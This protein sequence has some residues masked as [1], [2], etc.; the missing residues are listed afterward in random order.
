M[1][2]WK[3]RIKNKSFWIALIPAVLL[4]VQVI[5]AVFGYTL[6]LGELGD[7]LL[8]VV[9]A[10]FAVLTILG[11]VTDPTTAGLEIPNRLLLTRH[12]K[13]RTQFNLRPLL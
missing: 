10:L 1:I 9:N 2:N 8:A 3:V 4:L 5:A 13:K 12:L 7:K 11:I 6:D